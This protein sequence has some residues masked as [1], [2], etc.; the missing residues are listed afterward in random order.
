[1]RAA[2]RSSCW[3]LI[4]PRQPPK[5]GMGSTSA[6]DL[7]SGIFSVF[8]VFWMTYEYIWMINDLMNHESIICPFSIP[9]IILIDLDASRLVNECS[10]LDNQILKA[11]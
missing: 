6:G 5:K 7:F 3:Q 10:E 9:L 8:R 4:I 2:F 1:M 11:R